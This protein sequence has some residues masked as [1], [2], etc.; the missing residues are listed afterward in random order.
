ML[1]LLLANKADIYCL[2]EICYL[3][4]TVLYLITKISIEDAIIT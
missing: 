2:R 1:S 4:R 3:L